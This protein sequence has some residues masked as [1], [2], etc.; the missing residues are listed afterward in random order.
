MKDVA[1]HLGVSRQLVSLVIRGVPGP[2]EESR[3][4]ILTAADELGYRPNASARLLRQNRTR[5][6][7]ALFWMG[8]PFQVR[9]IE[10]LFVRAAER[11]FSLVLGPTTS[12]R[13]TDVVVAELMEERVEALVAFNPDPASRAF[14]DARELV[15]VVWLGEWVDEPDVDNV[16]VDEVEGLRLAVEHL[17]E[18]GHRDIIYVGGRGGTVGRVRAA[19]YRSAMAAAGLA[20]RA[21]VL[22]SDFSEEGG[23]SAARHI[24]GR[25]RR[26]T[27]VVCCG[28]QCA[29]GVLAV[30]ARARVDVPG[31]ISVVGFDD[32][33]VASL[34]YHRLTSVHQDVEAT[35]EATLSSV[36]DRLEGHDRPRRAS[37]TPTSLVV[38][39]STGRARTG[40]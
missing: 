17:M 26:P 33:Y 1:D 10:R 21:E 30:F 31:E 28:D 15:P 22:E 4:R 40:P 18:L 34:S 6:I 14:A 11:G 32:S 13:P 7:G 8:N 29:A 20:E 9:V 27:A 23:A 36:L 38:R 35:V 5:L 19:A 2:S 12:D 16:H 3:Q 24:V 39:E 37:A 25:S